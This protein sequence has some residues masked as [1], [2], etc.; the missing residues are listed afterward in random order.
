MDRFDYL[1][2]GLGAV[3]A[4]IGAKM[5]VHPWFEVPIE[6]SLGVVVL[7]LGASVVVSILFNRRKASPP[8]PP[9]GPVDG[10][11]PSG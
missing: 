9:D 7:L 3:L 10:A 11:S 2:Y 8:P 5:L 1:P 4:F 6:A